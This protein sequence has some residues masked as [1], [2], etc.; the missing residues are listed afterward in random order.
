MGQL[1]KLFL[2]ESKTLSFLYLFTYLQF[3]N[4]FFGNT[5]NPKKI[6]TPS[7]WAVEKV[8]YILNM[9]KEILGDF[10]LGDDETQIFIFD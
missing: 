7:K 2:T 3:S 1:A 9:D 4:L 10:F 8:I 6:F 5:F